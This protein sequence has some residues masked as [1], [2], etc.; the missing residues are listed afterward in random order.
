MGPAAA[1]HV[2]ESE[3]RDGLGPPVPEVQNLLCVDNLI[4]HAP[5]K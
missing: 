3:A 2:G 4:R 1:R 5:D